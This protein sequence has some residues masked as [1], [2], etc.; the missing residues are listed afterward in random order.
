MSNRLSRRHILKLISTSIAGI[1]AAILPSYVK[2]QGNFKR[3]PQAVRKNVRSLSLQEK[4]AF[5]NAIKVLK[6]T[7]A[8]N[9]QISIYDQFVALHVGTMGFSQSAP[10]NPNYANG[11]MYMDMKSASDA[12][13]GKASGP[14]V[15]ADAAHINAAFFPWHRE[16]IHR[17]EQALQSVDPNV[18]IPYWDWTDSEAWNV[19]FDEKFLGPANG[20]GKIVQLPYQE[21]I[22][23]GGPIESGN[24]SQANGWVLDE[25]LHFNAKGEPQGKSLLR[26]FELP[27][28]DKYPL[29]KED[30]E[31]ALAVNDYGNFRSAVEGWP[32]TD[33]EGNQVTKFSNHNVVHG[34]IGGTIWDLRVFPP[35]SNVIPEPQGTMVFV[36]TPYDPVFWL[37]HSNVDRLWT[38]WQNNGHAGSDFYPSNGQAYG[39][40]LNDRMWPWDGGQSTPAN[41]GP[42]YYLSIL[43]VFAPDDIVTPA[44]TLDVTKYNYTY[45]T[46][47]IR[48]SSPEQP[49]W[50]RPPEQPPWHRPPEQP[51][52]H[53]PPE[54][55]P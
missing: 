8:S 42:G 44:D 30:V 50:H 15:G 23:E 36:S 51:P 33:R 39:H 46:L 6:N 20:K 31:K 32:Y 17:F 22:F 34:T 5:V 14:A 28:F 2:A 49:P 29:P 35:P 40:N 48:S 4:A 38:E 1:T 9:A 45:D 52:W 24:F 37:L 43:P 54:Q 7:Y 19:I 47:W 18:T 16:Y 25:R 27:P 13:H 55:P 53:R 11:F 26:F 12:H 41:M 10:V 3:K 21:G